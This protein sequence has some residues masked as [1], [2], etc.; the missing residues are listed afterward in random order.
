MVIMKN[1]SQLKT[2]LIVN[3]WNATKREKEVASFKIWT[4]L[5][6]NTDYYQQLLEL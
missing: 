5:L 1:A 6:D 2:R 4:W 3:F